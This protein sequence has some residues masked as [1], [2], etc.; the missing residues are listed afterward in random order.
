MNEDNKKQLFQEP[1]RLMR[2]KLVPKLPGSV[3]KQVESEVERLEDIFLDARSPR[4]AIVGRRGSGKSTFINSI[5]QAPVAEIGSVKAQTGEGQWL[6]Y[7]NEDKDADMEIL[8]TRGLG[9][10]SAPAEASTEIDALEEVKSSMKDKCPDAFLFL[11]KAKEVDSRINEDIAQLM[12]LKNFVQKH[13]NYLPPVIGIVTQVDELDPVY[14]AEPPYKKKKLKNIDEAVEHLSTKLTNKM[15][16][17]AGV[18]PVCSYMVFEDEEIVYDRRWNTEEVVHF[19]LEHL[20]GSTWMQ[21]AKITQAKEIQRK[22]ALTVG[23]SASAVCGG[24]GAQ[25]IPI[26]DLPVITGIQIS[27]ITSIAYI[28]GRE[29]NRKSIAEFIGAMGVNIGAAYAFRQVA[30]SLSK[31]AFP[32]AG[33]LISGTVASIATWSLCKAAISYFIDKESSQEARAIFEKETHRLKEE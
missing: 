14:N 27:M 17:V 20:P 1:I 3:R 32:G 28:S 19:L 21:W 15:T 10:G 4:F 6:A 5:F 23:K 9:E 33:H 29:L 22:I 24:L 30:R 7:K 16:D 2:S 18:L 31:V 11:I 25:P 13:H 8:D 12:E 26:A